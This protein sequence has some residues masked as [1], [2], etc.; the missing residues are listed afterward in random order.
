VIGGSRDGCLL[1]Y[2]LI[3]KN[4]DPIYGPRVVPPV[5]WLSPLRGG[6]TLACRRDSP[7]RV[8]LARTKS[9][10]Q[11]SLLLDADRI[12]TSHRQLALTK[13]H[14][15]VPAAADVFV[16]ADAGTVLSGTRLSALPISGPGAACG[17]VP[18]DEYQEA[19]VGIGVPP[20]APVGLSNI[21]DALTCL[22]DRPW[23]INTQLMEV[24]SRTPRHDWY[25]IEAP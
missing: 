25:A 21:Y 16:A 20:S 24:W 12:Q 10:A 14:E 2:N 5:P 9:L 4:T 3:V 17:G 23:R 1:S 13:S 6:Y 22:G 19:D 15:A 8:A 7:F 18:G 11:R